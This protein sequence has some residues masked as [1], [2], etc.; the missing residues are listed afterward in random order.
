MNERKG[1]LGLRKRWNIF[2]KFQHHFSDEKT[3]K[4]KSSTFTQ[5][6]GQ[7]MSQSIF[8][9]DCW[10]NEKL[11][12]ITKMKKIYMW[13]R[14]NLTK[15]RKIIKFL[16]PFEQMQAFFDVSFSIV[17]KYFIFHL[18][19]FSRSESLSQREKPRNKK[20]RKYI[21]FC[22]IIKQSKFS[23]ETTRHKIFK[24]SILISCT[25][26]KFHQ[27]KSEWFNEALHKAVSRKNVF[28]RCFSP[29]LRE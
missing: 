25:F 18:K 13:I 4:D 20:F 24:N 22:I 17:I 16:K 12:R 23:P 15:A 9:A 2:F 19:S 27:I 1:F 14:K 21:L 7:K 6:S 3:L 10:V 26:L 5:T 29:S 11:F 8:S 28:E